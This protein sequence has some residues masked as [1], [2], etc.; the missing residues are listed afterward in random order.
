MKLKNLMYFLCVLSLK[1][2]FALLTS[3]SVFLCSDSLKLK[4]ESESSLL[5][6]LSPIEHTQSA[7][8]AATKGWLGRLRAD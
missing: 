4:S 5:P 6:A 7:R 8:K 3:V 1:E 2:Y